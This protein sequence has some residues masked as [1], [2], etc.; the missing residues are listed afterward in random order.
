MLA[1]EYW[2]TE[3]TGDGF[4]HGFLTTEYTEYTEKEGR[5]SLVSIP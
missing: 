2:Q 3:T 4:N 1:Y 5:Y